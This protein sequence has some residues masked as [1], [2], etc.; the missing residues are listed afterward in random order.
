MKSIF[1]FFKRKL[2]RLL[3]LCTI[4]ALVIL[5]AFASYN[6]SSNEGYSTLFINGEVIPMSADEHIVANITNKNCKI[7]Q[8]VTKTFLN[9]KSEGKINYT[10]NIKFEYLV[11]WNNFTIDQNKN[12]AICTFK[13]LALKTPVSYEIKQRQSERG[14]FVNAE[15][16][17][18]REQEFFADN[19]KFQQMMN[20]QGNSEQFKKLAEEQAQ[21]SLK[22]ILKDR[23][24]PML[25][26]AQSTAIEIKFNDSL[27]AEKIIDLKKVTK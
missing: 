6:S 16:L 15:K 13:K 18:A 10:L 5:W 17:E 23:V 19:G 12:I 4:L 26:I 25:K 21:K 1:R 22:Q 8:V 3:A 24:F 11:N 7:E 2:K 14:F 20:N 27:K 9:F